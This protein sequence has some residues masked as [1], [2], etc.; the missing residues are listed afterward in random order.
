MAWRTRPTGSVTSPADLEDKLLW[1]CPHEFAPFDKARELLLYRPPDTERYYDE[2]L[3]P[4]PEAD[5]S[6]NIYKR[7]RHKRIIE[8][9]VNLHH[10]IILYTAAKTESPADA[11]R[12][13]FTKERVRQALS[14]LSIPI[15]AHLSL[16]HP[17]VSDAFNQKYVKLFQPDTGYIPC[18]CYSKEDVKYRPQGRHFTHCHV[19]YDLGTATQFGYRAKYSDDGSN[20]LSLRIDILKELGTL[21]ARLHPDW[22]LHSITPS[23]SQELSKSW[24]EWITF[25]K[26]AGPFW[27]GTPVP[28]VSSTRGLVGRLIHSFPKP[29]N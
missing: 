22:K 28:P 24:Q 1:I 15:C 5:C 6:T 4:C 21:D 9:R 2:D 20:T 7:I 3:P 14:N 12:L 8:P 29:W 27:G 23:R 11:I 19:C 16:D 26:A 18:S 17:T 10:S 25:I 13:F